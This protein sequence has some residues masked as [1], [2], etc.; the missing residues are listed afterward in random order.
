[1]SARHIIWEWSGTLVDDRNNFHSALNCALM[2]RGHSPLT[3]VQLVASFTRPLRTLFER[4][5]GVAD[6]VEWECWRSIFLEELDELPPPPL[7]KQ[8][9]AA[10]T[11]FLLTGREQSI[12]SLTQVEALRRSVEHHGLPGYFHR[13]VG[14]G[15]ISDDKAALIRSFMTERNLDA[16]ELV[17]IGGSADDARIATAAGIRSVICD[18]VSFEKVDAVALTGLAAAAAS[19]LGEAVDLAFIGLDAC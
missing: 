12:I 13:I 19:T 9:Q 11:K 14:A 3:R 10:L 5:T 18:A 15:H 2:A 8:A 7:A 4:V 17:L 1:M 6:E 16:D